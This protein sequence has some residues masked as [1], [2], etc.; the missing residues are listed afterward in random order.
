MEV[1]ERGIALASAAFAIV[2]IAL[3]LFFAEKP[4]DASVAEA[5]FLPPN[6]LLKVGGTAVNVTADRFL[7]CRD[8]VCISVRKGESA[9]SQLVAAGRDLSVTGRVK[10]YLGRRYVEAQWVETG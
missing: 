9:S 10:E 8:Y 1:G 7:L 6:T 5:M 4:Y 3:L 2:G